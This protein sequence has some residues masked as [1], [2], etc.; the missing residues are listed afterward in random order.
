VISTLKPI[1]AYLAEFHSM[2]LR[3]LL[4]GPMKSNL[5]AAGRNNPPL[6]KNSS[7]RLQSSMGR[8]LAAID[9]PEPILKFKSELESR[10]A[11]F[12][13]LQWQIRPR[14]KK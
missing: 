3:T 12:R 8:K 10:T 7:E 13:L 9:M 4:V 5:N 11:I 2:S 6:P 1:A 14:L